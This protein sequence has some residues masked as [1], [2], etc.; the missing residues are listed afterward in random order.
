MGSSE[1][2]IKGCGPLAKPRSAH[3]CIEG[4][5]LVG[6]ADGFDGVSGLGVLEVE[7]SVVAADFGDESDPSEEVAVVFGVGGESGGLR[8]GVVAAWVVRV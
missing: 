6:G 1:Q 8:C 7:L 3:R 4:L 2:G 5:Q